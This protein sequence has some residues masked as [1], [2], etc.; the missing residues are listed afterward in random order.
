MH[1][2]LTLT[3]LF[4]YNIPESN[5]VYPLNKNKVKDVGGGGISLNPIHGG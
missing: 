3:V 2:L 1:Q 5:D 4:K